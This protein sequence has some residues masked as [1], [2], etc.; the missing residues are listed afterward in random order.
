MKDILV[1]GFK[2]ICHG[3]QDMYYK[4]KY[5]DDCPLIKRAKYPV[6]DEVWRL[7]GTMKRGGDC[8]IKRIL[9]I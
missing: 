5:C 9:K 4:K 3:A 7:F 2:V 6:C 8:Y 1:D